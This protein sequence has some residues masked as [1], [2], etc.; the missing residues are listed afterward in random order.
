MASDIAKPNMDG[1]N[2]AGAQGD[3]AAAGGKQANLKLAQQ[4]MALAQSDNAPVETQVS[5]QEQISTNTP[6]NKPAPIGGDRIDWG[7][8][9]FGPN[10]INPRP[11][12][13][14]PGE[15]PLR[16]GRPILGPGQ[17]IFL[18]PNFI[19]GRPI[20]LPPNFI[21]GQP[22]PL[23]P[24]CP[25]GQLF[26]TLPNVPGS[27]DRPTIDLVGFD[28]EIIDGKGVFHQREPAEHDDPAATLQPIGIIEYVDGEWVCTINLPDETAEQTLI[29]TVISV[30]P[31]DVDIVDP[32]EPDSK[33][34]I[35][36]GPP[37]M[38]TD[39]ADGEMVYVINES[40][41]GWTMKGSGESIEES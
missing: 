25:P 16:P 12:I 22:F 30:R 31:D 20:P 1:F 32:E 4:F 26:P 29:D 40:L 33:D 34:T 15:R 5:G 6:Q 36:V 10:P 11:P 7:F 24:H 39:F 19:P 18:P 14:G 2:H 8:P 13:F 17:P 37:I 23:P 35:P 38:L 28:V 21:P 41:G 9:E 3:L 27:N